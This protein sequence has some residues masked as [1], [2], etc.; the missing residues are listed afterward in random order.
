MWGGVSV[1]GLRYKSS[2]ISQS[3]SICA[4]PTARADREQ[5]AGSLLLPLSLS[6]PPHCQSGTNRWTQ[7]RSLDLPLLIFSQSLTPPGCFL[8]PS[9]F[10]NFSCPEL[11]LD[12]WAEC[13]NYHGG[14]IESVSWTYCGFEIWVGSVLISVPVFPHLRNVLDRISER[15]YIYVCVG[16]VV[17]NITS[18]EIKCVD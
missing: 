7:H 18:R 17:K 3:M 8:P 2:R 4:A 1:E 5:T 9:R 16:C 11:P 13:F 10:L 14:T 15:L 6:L 12:T